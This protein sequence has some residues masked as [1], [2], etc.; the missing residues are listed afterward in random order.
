MSLAGTQIAHREYANRP[1][2]ERYASVADLI[3]AAEKDR[4]LSVEREYN[5]K[6]LQIGADHDTLMLQSPKG[7]A[8]FSHWAFGQ[9]CRMLSAPASYLRTLPAAIAASALNY[10]ISET[11]VGTRSTLLVKAPNGSPL[12]IIRSATSDTYGRLWD[13]QLYDAMQ[14]QIFDGK[15]GSGKSWI[16]P[17]TWTGESAGAYRGDRNSFVIQ[18]DGG[19]IVPNPSQSTDGRDK[20]SRG[21]NRGVLVSNSEVGE[22][23]VTIECIYFDAVCGNHL[24]MGAAIDR[25]YRRR[26]VGT[27]VLRD[28]L[29]EIAKIARTWTS[30]ST[31][32]DTAIIRSLVDH[33]LAHTKETVIDELQAIGFSKADA[34]EAYRLAETTESVSPRSFWGL[35][36]GATRLSQATEYQDERFLIDQLA[37]KILAKGAKLVHA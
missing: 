14:R 9:F 20:G 3:A 12:P 35:A 7:Q 33:E 32:R 18:V 11:P 26:H 25:T 31:E 4:A 34:T 1:K 10:G 27:R 24:L 17:P 2:D 22:R 30:Q 21:M 6:D 16:L 37:G 15:S 19:S 13:C 29:M 23:S 5:V 36:S 8:S 28:T